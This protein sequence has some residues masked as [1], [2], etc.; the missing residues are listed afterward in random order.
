MHLK[1]FSLLRSAGGMVSFAPAYDLLSTT[2][3]IPEGKDELAL[4]VNGKRSNLRKIDFH[5]LSK[6]L[7]VSETVVKNF[8]EDFSRALPRAINFIMKSSLPSATQEEYA[9]LIRA[10]ASKIGLD[11]HMVTYGH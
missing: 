10:R 1:N 4:T 3:V 5:E 11:S 6:R 8:L 9:R 7:G 2:L